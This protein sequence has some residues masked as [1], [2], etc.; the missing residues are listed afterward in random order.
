MVSHKAI[1]HMDKPS[2]ILIF[3]TYFD[4]PNRNKLFEKIKKVDARNSG[5]Q[6]IYSD[7]NL[8]TWRNYIESCKWNSCS[9]YGGYVAA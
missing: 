3:V 6:L 8:S 9:I 5:L 4:R 7:K 2:V 1:N